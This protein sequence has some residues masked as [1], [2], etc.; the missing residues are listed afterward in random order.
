MRRITDPETIRQVCVYRPLERSL[1]PSADGF[2]EFI[3]DWLKRWDRDT[4]RAFRKAP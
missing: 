4:Q 3:G 1:S 2:A